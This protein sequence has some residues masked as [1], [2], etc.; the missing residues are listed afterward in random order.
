MHACRGSAVLQTRQ[1]RAAPVH[2][3][4]YISPGDQCMQPNRRPTSCVNS[5]ASMFAS[6]CSSDATP[7]RVDPNTTMYSHDCWDGPGGCEAPARE[8]SRLLDG[9]CARRPLPFRIVRV[10]RNP[11]TRRRSASGGSS[12]SIKPQ[13]W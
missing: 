9:S 8:P 7:G 11:C 4:L 1:S 3:L 10:L 6:G 5:F 12:G 13:Q 2:M